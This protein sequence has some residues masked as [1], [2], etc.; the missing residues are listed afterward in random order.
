MSKYEGKS[1]VNMTKNLTTSARKLNQHQKQQ[2]HNLPVNEDE[3]LLL[4]L[5]QSREIKRK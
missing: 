5:R 1:I 4:N 3:E 2:K